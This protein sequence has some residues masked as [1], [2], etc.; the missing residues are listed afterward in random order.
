MST[1]RCPSLAYARATVSR[2]VTP[3]R[4]MPWPF[5]QL[6]A[7]RWRPI[8]G[9]IALAVGAGLIVA[10][11]VVYYSQAPGYL[12]GDARTYLAAG[13][14]LNAGHPLY[15]LS[16]GDRP[17]AISPPWWTV[18]LVSPPFIAVLWRPLAA[19]PNELGIAVWIAGSVAC[20]VA[21]A[22]WLHRRRPAATRLLLAALSVPTGREI[23]LGHVDG[24]LP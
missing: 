7:G 14:R 12:G 22:A 9:A 1:F 16:P 19:L 3:S 21:V 17:V 13:E 4:E 8:F 6:L 20:I 23:V 2:V 5:V 11:V 15:V 18:P 24:S 10:T